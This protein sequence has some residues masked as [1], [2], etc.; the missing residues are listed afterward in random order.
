MTP[1]QWAGCLNQFLLIDDPTDAIQVL[2]L[3]G[4]YPMLYDPTV[5][6]FFEKQVMRAANENVSKSADSQVIKDIT[7]RNLIAFQAVLDPS[8][9]VP[10]MYFKNP[11]A[12]AG[13]LRQ[14]IA[15]QDES[16]LA[17]AADLA[18]GLQ[19]NELQDVIL[20]SYSTDGSHSPTAV[21]RRC[22]QVATNL[23]SEKRIEESQT[24]ML[25]GLIS[26]ATLAES[27][28]QARPKDQHELITLG[29]RYCE[30]AQKLCQSLSA[31]ECSALFY[32]IAA[33]G[34][35]HLRRFPEAKA[36]I[37]MAI[38]I[39]RRLAKTDLRFVPELGKALYDCAVVCQDL[40]DLRSA[41]AYV[42]E[43]ARLSE[44]GT[45]Q[46]VSI[47]S[48]LQF[49]ILRE[50]IAEG[51]QLAYDRNWREAQ[52][53]FLELKELGEALDDIDAVAWA[54]Q[55]LG[56]IQR[57]QGKHA[58]GM[59]H[60]EI[61]LDLAERLGERRLTAIILDQIATSYRMR[62]EYETAY[63]YYMKALTTH[64]RSES[65]VKGNLSELHRLMGNLDEAE[66]LAE[67]S[68]RA[69]KS[70]PTPYG[71]GLIHIKR[72][73][74]AIFKNDLLVAITE[75]LEAWRHG[76]K[77]GHKDVLDVAKEVVADICKA[78]GNDST[79]FAQVKDVL[80]VNF[81]ND[82]S[83]FRRTLWLNASN[84]LGKRHMTCE[85]AEVYWQWFK[86]A[87]AT[88]D[89]QDLDFLMRKT[90][91][92]GH[93]YARLQDDIEL[94][95][96]SKTALQNPLYLAKT[97]VAR[98]HAFGS[99]G[100]FSAAIEQAQVAKELYANASSFQEVEMCEILIQELLSQIPSDNLKTV[101]VTAPA[102]RDSFA[103]PV[104]GAQAVS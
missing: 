46:E 95:L 82:E 58:A 63:E 85:A 68:R 16:L 35:S 102:L 52:K 57:D 99:H 100:E 62:K 26:K 84:A 78:F 8:V 72:A 51:K 1:E 11:V 91:T 69:Y 45:S 74:I 75:V 24:M 56:R 40:G 20:N 6:D 21:A 29:L 43:T 32:I 5:S 87:T 55:Y 66:R 81:R 96:R 17:K 7:T 30:R 49:Q 13:C 65:F 34:M 101:C 3:F 9:P 18:K 31:D 77:V 64:P 14:S 93:S 12:W 80:A 86:L 53:V 61:A 44:G 4:F 104:S 83:D 19:P 48:E 39:L 28:I 10:P 38:A 76:V 50:Y 47:G 54:E 60:Y 37:E 33:H 23:A 67:E 92:K 103:A 89:K 94:Q 88:S 15:L 70:D 97:T 42:E 22:Y 90:P 27:G 41:M 2:S 73:Q 71:A 25:F 79:T 59:K 98:A 36:A